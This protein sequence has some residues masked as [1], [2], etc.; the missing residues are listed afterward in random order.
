MVTKVRNWQ[1]ILFLH[2]FFQGSSEYTGTLKVP[3]CSS[4][5]T[6]VSLRSSQVVLTRATSHVT[7]NEQARAYTIYTLVSTCSSTTKPQNLISFQA[8]MDGIFGKSIPIF[9]TKN[10]QQNESSSIK[11]WT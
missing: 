6:A 2:F 11:T 1:Y 8:S 7:D 9:S 10:N 4:T 3:E 5:L